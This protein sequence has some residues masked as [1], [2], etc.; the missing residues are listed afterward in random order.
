MY[1][2]LQTGGKQYIAKSGDILKVERLTGNKGDI[3]E[4]DKVLCIK[5][6]DENL[7]LGKPYL[8]NAKILARIV[9]QGKDKKIVI[10]KYKRRKKYRRKTGHRQQITHLLITDIKH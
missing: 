8:E 7:H 5:D 4:I 10:G 3:I 1:A 9:F 6:E 2:V